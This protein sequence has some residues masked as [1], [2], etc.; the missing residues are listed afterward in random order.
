MNS[1]SYFNISGKQ[2]KI[3]NANMV[4]DTDVLCSVYGTFF[5]YIY[6]MSNT[7]KSK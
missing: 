2:T 7:F 4:S 6:I 3:I 1:I 5:T